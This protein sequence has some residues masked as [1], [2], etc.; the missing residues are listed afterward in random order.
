MA[1]PDSVVYGRGLV[2]LQQCIDSQ[3]YGSLMCFLGFS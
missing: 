1:A 3:K 2:Q